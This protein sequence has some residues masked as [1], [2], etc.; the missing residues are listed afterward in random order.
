MYQ[1]IHSRKSYNFGNLN[2]NE[3]EFRTSDVSSTNAD[4]YWIYLKKMTHLQS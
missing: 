4:M 2:E 1:R 3:N